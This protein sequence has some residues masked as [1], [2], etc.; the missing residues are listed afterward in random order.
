MVVEGEVRAEEAV[1][2]FYDRIGKLN[3]KLNAFI[4]LTRGGA[5]KK[6]K[7][8]DRKVAQGGR[9]GRLAGLPIAVKDNICVKDVE[10]TCAS[11]IL[12]GYRPPYNATVIEKIERE[13][14]IVIGST[15]MD[16]YAMGSSTE[17]S[18]YGPTRNPWSLDRVAGGSSGGSA[19]C[20]TARM[21]P[22]ALGSD[23]GGSIRCPA[24]FC[25][26]VGL[27]PTYG[28]VSRY[29]LIAYACSLEQIGP[30]ARTVEDCLLLLNVIAGGDL[31]D[32]T[33]IDSP[34]PLDRERVE[35]RVEGVR[36]AVAKELFGEGT[37]PRV[38]REVWNSIN[39]L[40]DLGAS[41]EEVSIPS[42]KYALAA[43]YIIA[44][45][46]ASSNLA[47]YDGVRYGFRVE[48]EGD[49]SKTYLKT[50][51][52]GF[53][54]EVKRRILL[55]TFALSAG[56]YGRYYLKALKVRSVV[57]NEL[58][59]ILKKFNVIISPTMPTPP[60]KIREKV[61]DPLSMYMM[62]VDTVPANLAGL[63]AISIPCGFVEGLPVGL[64]IMGKFFREADVFNVALALE[65][66]LEFFKKVPEV[67]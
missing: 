28:L 15:N 5:L 41:Y 39:L 19:A 20:V 9:L 58:L 43:Y 64:Q 1:E 8:V 53:G 4:R 61:E 56:Y 32:S 46:E 35:G 40:E 13:D 60:F 55:G 7:E 21:A 50:R 54:A 44:M 18:F 52:E 22:L 38:G 48:V 37:D 16:E 63:P 33:T 45:S 3:P 51:G 27:K 67:G 57:K 36:L 11:R 30:I 66:E 2:V 6:A 14:G 59:S 62:D 29:G 42:L 23:T 17:N 26:A 10:V 34:I 49:W 12:S 65:R 24:S 47:R 31:K 25:S